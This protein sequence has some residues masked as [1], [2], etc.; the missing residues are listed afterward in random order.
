VKDRSEV[1]FLFS[2]DHRDPAVIA[3]RRQR[4]EQRLNHDWR[5]AFQRLVEQQHLRPADQRSSDRQHLLL[6]ARQPVP[7]RAAPPGERGK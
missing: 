3:D 1:G 6:A 2:Q 5:Q 7:G 4:G